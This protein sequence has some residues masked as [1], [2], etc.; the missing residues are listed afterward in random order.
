MTMTK[1]MIIIPEMRER[2]LYYLLVIGC[3]GAAIDTKRRVED[4]LCTMYYSFVVDDVVV[5]V[6]LIEGYNHQYIYNNIMMMGSVIIGIVI[7]IIEIRSTI[8][9]FRCYVVL[10][11][12][13][14]ISFSVH[15]WWYINHYKQ[16]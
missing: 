9:V 3:M 14:C 12:Q 5:V 8:V 16:K 11:K 4:V 2:F 7:I 1:I 13:R 15:I 6:G 10:A